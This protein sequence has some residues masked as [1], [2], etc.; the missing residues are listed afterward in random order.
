VQDK[1]KNWVK[2]LPWAEYWYNTSYHSAI[3]MTPFQ[4]VYGREVPRLLRYKD[5]PSTNAKVEKMTVD[6]DELLKELRVN[7]E[8]AQ[9]RMEAQANKHRREVEYVVGE[10]V[11]LKLKPYRQASVAKRRN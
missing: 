2:L 7:L 5:V 11:Y 8:V 9:K 4:A 1:P 6:R 3:K 10:M